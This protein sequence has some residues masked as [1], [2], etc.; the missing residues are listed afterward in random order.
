MMTT[1]IILLP[2][3]T[4]QPLTVTEDKD[5]HVAG[6][7]RVLIMD[8]EE[9]VRDV[10]AKSL[11]RLGFD[12]DLVH[13]GSEALARYR[14]ALDSGRPF[15]VVILDLTVPGGMGGKETVQELLKINPNV[16]TLICSGYSNDRAVANYAEFGFSGV[17]AK[18]FRPKELAQAVQNLISADQFA[19]VQS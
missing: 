5:V 1:F 2:A 12:V 7:G 17:V 6:T 15:D 18:P 19:P 3:T 8:D 14:E 16:K 4:E 10:A 11:K 9:V 13:N